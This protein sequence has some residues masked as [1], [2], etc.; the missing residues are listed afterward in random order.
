MILLHV[1]KYIS[2]GVNKAHQPSNFTLLLLMCFFD[3]S[4]LVV[5]L[6]ALSPLIPVTY[7]T[8]NLRGLEFEFSFTFFPLN[9]L[10]KFLK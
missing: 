4:V 10:S 7:H 8:K 2:I 1:Y 5:T 9:F 3:Y 6:L